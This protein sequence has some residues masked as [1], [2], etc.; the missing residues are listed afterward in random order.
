V[1][2]NQILLFCIGRQRK[3]PFWFGV[4]SDC[5]HS[6]PALRSTFSHLS[7]RRGRRWQSLCPASRVTSSA[8]SPLP[9]ANWNVMHRPLPKWIPIPEKS[10]GAEFEAG[11]RTTSAPN[12]LN[13]AEAGS[14]RASMSSMAMSNDFAS[15]GMN[16]EHHA[17]QFYSY[18]VNK[19]SQ[20]ERNTH[21]ALLSSQILGSTSEGARYS[22][23]FLESERYFRIWSEFA[24]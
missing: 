22:N 9:A 10:I 20:R 6:G 23:L 3:T 11:I 17:R 4:E 21:R 8:P 24:I 18:S 14:P 5:L 12:C 19:L 13:I 1:I 16:P 2:P 7:G 15:N